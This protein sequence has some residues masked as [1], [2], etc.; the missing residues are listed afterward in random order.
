M[1]HTSLI[2]V[3]WKQRQVDVCEF[4]A[5]LVYLFSSRPAR[6]IKSDSIFFLLKAQNPIECKQVMSPELL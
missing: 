3:L 4:Q 1:V 5:S 6:A 2:P